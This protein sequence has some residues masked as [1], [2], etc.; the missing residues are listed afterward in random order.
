MGFSFNLSRSLEDLDLI[1]LIWTLFVALFPFLFFFFEPKK[2]KAIFPLLPDSSCY[3]Y[4][5]RDSAVSP[6]FGKEDWGYFKDSSV[7]SLRKLYETVNYSLF[8]FCWNYHWGLVIFILFI[9]CFHSR[10]SWVFHFFILNFKK[11][12]IEFMVYHFSNHGTTRICLSEHFCLPSFV[13]F[14]CI[15]ISQGQRRAQR[16][17]QRNVKESFFFRS[18][19]IFWLNK[20]FLFFEISIETSQHSSKRRWAY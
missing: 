2:K 7:S 18:R 3:E 14:D 9:L 6:F 11:R 20:T 17:P 8:F 13:P 16:N 1:F 15:P 5:S 12:K 19:K 10:R 4:H